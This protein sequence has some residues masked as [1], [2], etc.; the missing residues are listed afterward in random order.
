MSTNPYKIAY[1]RATSEIAEIDAQIERLTR[2]KELLQKLLDPL[3][4][5]LSESASVTIPA[6]PFYGSDTEIPVPEAPTQVSPVEMDETNAHARGNGRS[7]PHEEI[8]W[9]AYSFWNE[10]GQ[11][12][13]Y[14]EDDW[15]RA[16]HALHDAPY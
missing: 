11:V 12:H 5:L 15:F 8:A 7:I 13:G 3:E 9:L 1:E 4:P 14:H 10:R 6:A 2:R 16:A